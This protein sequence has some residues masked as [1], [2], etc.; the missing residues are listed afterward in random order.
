MLSL[1]SRLLL[2]AILT[3]SYWDPE[4]RSASRP[5]E[6]MFWQKLILGLALRYHSAKPLDQGIF[7]RLL[8]PL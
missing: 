2:S 6:F 8:I 5:L 3:R 7:S 1:A 4:G